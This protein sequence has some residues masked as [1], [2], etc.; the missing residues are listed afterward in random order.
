MRPNRRSFVKYAS[1]AAAGNAAGL[2]PF[3]LM[4]ALAQGT[5][6]Y[7]ALV[8][9]FLFGGND[10]NNMLVPF[11]ASG[12]AEYARSRGPLAI[13]QNQLLPIA[14][15]PNFALNPN[16]GAFQ[17]LLDTRV[18]AL[19]TNVGT[20][21]APTS[22]AQYLAGSVVPDSLFSHEDQGAE[23]QNG[24]SS[25]A[26]QSGW[27]GRIADNLNAS[28]N[29][30]AS[31]PMIFSLAGDSLFCNGSSSSPVS[32]SGSSFGSAKCHEEDATC[33]S[34]Q[35]NAQ[36]L[37]KFDSGLSLVQADNLIATNSYAYSKSLSDVVRSIT[38]LKTEFPAANGL[39]AQL[40]Q[41]AQL[42]QVRSALG[43]SRQ[44]FFAGIGGFDTHSDQLNGQG[45]LLAQLG[46]ALAAFNQATQELQVQNNVTTFTMSDFSRALRPN[47]N[48]GSDHGWGSHHI[49]MGGAVRGG[50]LYG[51]FPSLALGGPDD[52]GS[53]GRLIPST[54]IV[55]YGSTLAQW[56]G[57][58]PNQLSSIFPGV[59][60]FPNLNL[61]FLG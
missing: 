55:Q 41:I 39:A 14:A 4:N 11:D 57:V 42:I 52:A 37:L 13:A 35:A 20:L 7:K 23:W 30:G 21:I 29:P 59:G 26:N 28:R 49:V 53:D 18:A 17:T 34:R 22:R 44:I 38:P 19:V 58:A 45:G 10:A 24:A 40:G 54:S 1:L 48:S 31:V 32:V 5:S 50:R 16:M 36:A 46:P 60:N 3:G 2:Q 12:Y 33:S 25:K 61:G 47:S 51:T 56:F 27:A 9:I 43:Q 6:D 15:T 8:C